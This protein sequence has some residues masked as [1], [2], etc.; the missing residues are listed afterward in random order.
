MAEA[1]IAAVLNPSYS[2]AYQRFATELVIRESCGCGQATGA[3]G[4]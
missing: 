2:A 1:A 4:A 3:S